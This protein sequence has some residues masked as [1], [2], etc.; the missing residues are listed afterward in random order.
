MLISFATL[1]FIRARL[2]A[3]DIDYFISMFS[4]D[5]LRF[6]ISLAISFELFISFSPLF[7]S[8]YL[9]RLIS[10]PSIAS[11]RFFTIITLFTLM[12]RY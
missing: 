11:Y 5:F 1:R 12:M 2:K 6:F 3:F 9:I 10:Q 7:S 8:F 4:F